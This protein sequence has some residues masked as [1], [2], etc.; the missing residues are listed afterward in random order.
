M[1]DGQVLFN[2]TIFHNIHYGHL[3]ATEEEVC[4]G[5]VLLLPLFIWVL[6]IMLK[7]LSYFSSLI[8][9]LCVY[10]LRCMMPLDVQQFMTLS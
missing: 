5:P 4:D 6:Q 2:D 3:S 9:F 7:I 8:F 1:L 10:V